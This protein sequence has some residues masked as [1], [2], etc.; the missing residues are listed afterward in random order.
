MPNSS[1]ACCP[2]TGSSALA[3]SA[4]EPSG[5][6]FPMVAPVAMMMMMMKNATEQAKTG[7]AG[8]Q[9]R[10][11][12][13]LLAGLV[14]HPAAQQTRQRD[15]RF[16]HRSPAGQPLGT[17]PQ[18]MPQP[19]ARQGPATHHVAPPDWPNAAAV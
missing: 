8:D 12:A 15:Q 9:V 4:V 6:V 19:L 2:A 11:P 13:D 17:L 16:P 3:A 18:G 1:S 14:V 10:Q 7:P 5:P